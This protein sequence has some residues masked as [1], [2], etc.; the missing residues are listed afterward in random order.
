MISAKSWLEFSKEFGGNSLRISNVTIQPLKLLLCPPKLW[1]GCSKS[2]LL[3]GNRFAL[4]KQLCTMRNRKEHCLFCLVNS[5]GKKSFYTK[6]KSSQDASLSANLITSGF[7]LALGDMFFI[8]IS[9][10]WSP[11]LPSY[12]PPSELLLFRCWQKAEIPMKIVAVLPGE[13]WKDKVSTQCSWA[14][15]LTLQVNIQICVKFLRL[16]L[17]PPHVQPAY[18]QLC[19]Y[20]LQLFIHSG[21]L[22]GK[23]WTCPLVS[24][25]QHK[26]GSLSPW[27]G[28]G[29]AKGS[30]AA[31]T[32]RR[33]C[34]CGPGQAPDTPWWSHPISRD[35]AVPRVR[36]APGNFRL[37]LRVPFH[38][39]RETPSRQSWAG[40][41]CYNF[42]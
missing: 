18:E 34:P 38:T 17:L 32:G 13:N 33:Q 16:P 24:H 42:Q 21:G 7:F 12:P 31:C 40:C 5:E 1:E 30:G 4:G 41:R 20:H 26:P 23:C 37:V 39:V 14:S 25:Q 6:V 10:S 19:R 11:F 2:C 36:L 8:H 29:W 15:D 35:T 22:A 28:W 3:L 9:V 27:E